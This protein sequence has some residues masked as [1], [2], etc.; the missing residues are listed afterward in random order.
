MAGHATRTPAAR[1]VYD[2]SGSY[3]YEDIVRLSTR[4]AHGLRELGV[5]S[6]D[7]VAVQL[8]NWR[9]F[10]PTFLGIER[11][12]AVVN[13]LATI[14]R[15]RELRQMLQ[16]GRA[17]VL[18]VPANFRGWPHAERA[19]Q[20]LRDLPDLKHI[21]VVGGT[22]MSGTV[23]WDEL[24]E[25][26]SRWERDKISPRGGTEICELAFTSGTTGQPKGV[27]HS[28]NSAVCAVRSTVRRQGF[29]S[30]DVFHV[31]SPV[32]HNAGYFY[33]VRLALEAG[34]RLVMQ[35]FWDADLMVELVRSHRVTYSL[36]SPTHLFDMLG[37]QSATREALSSLRV[38]ICSGADLPRHLARSALD[39]I[40]QALCR[41]FGM[42]EIGHATSTDN[43]SPRDKLI[44]TDGNPQ[45]E[46]SIRIVAEDDRVLPAG[47]EGHVH[48]RGAFMFAGY[49]QGP[50]LTDEYFTG[51]WFH[52]GDL[53]RVDA[54]GYLCLTGRI[55]DVI[56]RGAEKL[57]V[58][59]IEEVLG[60]HPRI[61][62]VALIPVTDSRLGERAVACVRLR[63][64]GAL[65]LGDVTSFLA[66]RRVTTQFWPER[67][68]VMDS[69]PKTPA[70][71]IQ[72]PL[73][74]QLVEGDDNRGE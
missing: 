36:G 17:R 18:V 27:L 39:V 68:V 31:A 38:Y 19:V 45:P 10:V 2:A 72:K 49:L 16:V 3:S 20:L 46:M 51:D 63:D 21:V 42:T 29:D 56:I 43:E 30:H 23:W 25:L 15:E 35:D 55:K 62:E 44:E 8:P 53:G 64:G 70:G 26:G 4:V 74:R 9:E 50:E 67:V 71:K 57:P 48:V 65:G 52:T 6:Q 37:S 11:I 22:R 58:R 12:G 40:P 24:L 14:L 33:G 69:F 28:H 54:D 60:E 5:R 34:G 1:A 7:V 73:L 47:I 32:G 59:E 61:V 41:V 13:P 66:D